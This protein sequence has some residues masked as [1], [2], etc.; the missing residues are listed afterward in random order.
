MF[1]PHIWNHFETV[2]PRTNNHVE[3]FNFK[4]NQYSFSNHPK[5]YQL[6]LFFRQMETKISQKY[7]KRVK[8]AMFKAYRRPIDVQRD[9]LKTLLHYYA[10][11]LN[12]YLIYSSKLFRFDKSL[13]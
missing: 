9:I 13:Q 11:S 12:N 3:G 8:G 10:I 4:L 5:I 2:G 1:P 6:I 7:I